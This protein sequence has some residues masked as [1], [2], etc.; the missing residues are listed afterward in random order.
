MTDTPKDNVPLAA[1]LVDAP[2]Q[3]EVDL[4]KLEA[5][6]L[7]AWSA[8]GFKEVTKVLTPLTPTQEQHD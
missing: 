6:A 3:V 1:W 5:A 8:T 7:A 4:D 2:A